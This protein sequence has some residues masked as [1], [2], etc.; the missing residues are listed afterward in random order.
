[1]LGRCG[2]GRSRVCGLDGEALP[3][4][5]FDLAHRTVQNDVFDFFCDLRACQTSRPSHDVTNSPATGERAKTDP[6]AATAWT[7]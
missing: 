5:I 3:L 1:M 4:L 6:Q 2:R 7:R